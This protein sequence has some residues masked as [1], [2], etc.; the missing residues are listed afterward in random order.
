MGQEIDEAAGDARTA[1]LVLSWHERAALLARASAAGWSAI[2][3]DDGVD[4]AQS[5]ADSG[6]AVI[7]VD[8]RGSVEPALAAVGELGGVVAFHA[9]ALLVLVARDDIDAVGAFYAAGATHFLVDSGDDGELSAAL[10]FAARHAVR[11]G[12]G[13]GPTIDR[14]GGPTYDRDAG[15]ARRWLDDRI[16]AHRP[17]GVVLA[18]LSRL[19]I[20]NAAYGRPVG[21]ALIDAAGRRIAATARGVGGGDLSTLRIGAA[22]YA[23]L[24]ED[25]TAA[26]IEALAARLGEALARPFV[27]QGVTAALGSRLGIALA[28]PG[29]DAAALMQRAP[30]PVPGYARTARCP[31]RRGPPQRTAPPRPAPPARHVPTA[32]APRPR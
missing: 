6:A 18:S 30:A 19:D 26:R 7:L 14:R 13:D 9:A 25:A 27:V 31:D 15:D 16:A 22:E 11:L 3:P 10:R 4:I 23:L 12:G 21:D 29:D 28:D 20:V 32:P 17:V 8:A 5:F 24:V 1:L 2:V